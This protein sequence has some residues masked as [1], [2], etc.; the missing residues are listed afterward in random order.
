MGRL[1]RGYGSEYHLLDC[2]RR[3]PETLDAAILTALGVE[4][5]SIEWLYPTRDGEAKE[6]AGLGFLRSRSDPR[7]EAALRTWSTFWPRGRQASWDGIAIASGPNLPP[8]WLLIEAKANWPEFASPPCRAGAGLKT[9]EQALGKVKKRWGVHRFFCWTGSYYQFANRLAALYVLE[10]HAIP[11]MLVGVYIYG[12]QFPDG[13]P[14]P[15]TAAEWEPLLEA[16]R[17]TLGLVREPEGVRDVFLPA[18]RSA[19]TQQCV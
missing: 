5:A 8:T 19:S 13:T 4:G 6:P 14:C 18:L 12:D 3:K 17:R 15:A 7:H 2:R 9:I 10:K 11:A 16:R 1:G